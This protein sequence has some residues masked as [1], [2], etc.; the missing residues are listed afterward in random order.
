[1]ALS[2]GI[3]IKFIPEY[4]GNLGHFTFFLLLLIGALNQ[5]KMK[6]P[7]QSIYMGGI[8]NDDNEDKDVAAERT[9]V[10]SDLSNQAPV[11]I[12][13]LRKVF[14][15]Y[16]MKSLVKCKATTEFEAVAGLDLGIDDSHLLALLGHNGAGKTTTIN[17]MTGLLSPTA[18]VCYLYGKDIS[19]DMDE[20]RD[21]IGYCPQHDILWSDLTTREHMEIICEI[22]AIPQNQVQ[23]LISQR[24]DDVQLLSVSEHC[25][26][27]FSGGMK[28]RLS[29]SLAFIGDPKVVFLD[30]PTTGMDPYVR[31]DVWNL[32][33]RLKKGRAVIMTTHSMEEA[34]VLGDK[35]AIMALGKLMAVGSSTHLK[36]RFA[37]YNLVTIV[38]IEHTQTVLQLLQTELPGSIFERENAVE[39][40]NYLR[41]QLPSLLANQLPSFLLKLE[42]MQHLVVDFSISQTTL[43]GVFLNVTTATEYLASTKKE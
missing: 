42:S 20:I 2:L 30:E 43:E 1:M 37:G 29:V 19:S 35:I 39:G 36:N 25:V 34:D 33:L 18:G 9:K 22:K 13:G 21:I 3:S 14:K 6:D 32:I 31:R 23:Q 8:N 27:T 41:F 15:S 12:S 16:S 10:R 7:S 28:R 11:K 40:V 4:M 5:K 26:G 17:M 24:L 38:P